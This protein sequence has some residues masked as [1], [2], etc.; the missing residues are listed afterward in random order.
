M[1]DESLLDGTSG[2]DPDSCAW[3]DCWWWEAAGV[4]R[5]A[6]QPRT[7]ERPSESAADGE[8]IVVALH[9]IWVGE[10]L[11][12]GAAEELEPWQALGFDLDGVCTNPVGCAADP[13]DAVSCTNAG[14]IVADGALCRDNALGRIFF[15]AGAT[16]LGTQ[17]GVNEDKLNC[18][19]RSGSFSLL[20][21]ISGYDGDGDDSNVRLDVYPAHEVDPPLPYDCSASNWA[22]QITWD[23]NYTWKVDEAS[24]ETQGAPEGPS[25]IN[26]PAAYVKNEYLVAHLLDPTTLPLRGGDT[27]FYPGLSLTLYQGVV[28]G[29]L[30]R[31]AEGLWSVADGMIAGRV[32]R[33]DLI[34]SVEDAGFCETTAAGDYTAF[35]QSVDESLDVLAN[36]SNAETAPCDALSIGIRFQAE[37]AKVGAAVAL[38][39]LTACPTN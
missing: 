24:L 1:Y 16:P 20:F 7:D 30:V 27:S 23:A 14:G 5:T 18:G 32:R 12:P 2:F 3:G 25:T 4:C 15:G 38:A 22:A 26:D 9:R 21:R 10:S 37:Q 28:A 6:D 11:P 8:P 34:A 39:P 19:L 33:D 31:T 36:G 35:T 13:V 29:R 17:F